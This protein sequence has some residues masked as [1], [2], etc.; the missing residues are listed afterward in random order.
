MPGIGHPETPAPVIHTMEFKRIADTR[1]DYVIEQI[2]ASAPLII[3]ATDELGIPLDDAICALV[4]K[5]LN[6][7]AAD[8]H[9]LVTFTEKG[10]A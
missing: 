2:T 7:T 1:L 6:R 8:D 4:R 5:A 9:Q 10:D 3:T